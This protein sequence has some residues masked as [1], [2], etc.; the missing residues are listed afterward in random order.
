MIDP[1]SIYLLADDEDEPKHAPSTGRNGDAE[2]IDGPGDH[3]GPE[4]ARISRYGARV[5][6]SDGV[7][8][9]SSAIEDG[10]L[11][12]STPDEDPG[13]VFVLADAEE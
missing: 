11:D 6:D 4:N 5:T 12:Y 3:P 10:G 2:R 1:G 8:T 7:P 9:D 13:S